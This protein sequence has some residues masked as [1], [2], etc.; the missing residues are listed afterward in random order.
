MNAN[1]H[2]KNLSQKMI[3]KIM[4]GYNSCIEQPFSIIILCMST[5]RPKNLIPLHAIQN[6]VAQHNASIF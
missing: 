6:I 2:E 3:L 5:S 1:A 4:H